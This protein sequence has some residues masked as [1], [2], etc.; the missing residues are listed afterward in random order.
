MND[1]IDSEP[2][3]LSVDRISPVPPAHHDLLVVGIGASA[4]GIPALKA[5]F[6]AMPADS[7][8]A[9]VVI[10]HLSRKHESH[11]AEIL[12]S[13]TGMTVTQVRETLSVEPNTVYVIPPGKHLTMV[14]GAITL[15]EPEQ[16]LGRRVPVDLLFRT[17][18]D[19]YG[20]NAVC[21]VL[22][23]T[24]TD[25][26]L[27]LKRVKESGGIAIVQ[28]PAEAEFAEM[29]RSAIE[30]HLAD[31]ILP[32]SEMPAKLLTLKL[33]ATKFDLPDDIEMPPNVDL[34]ADALREVLTLLRIRTGHDF[35]HYKRPTLMRRMAR[36]MM[37]HDLSDLPGYL[38][39]LREHPEELQSLLQDL[40]ISVTNFFRDS[41]VFEELE[42]EVIPKIFQGKNS[43]DQVRVWVAACATGEEAYTIAM[44]LCEYAENMPGDPPGIQVFA[45]DIDERAIAAARNGYYNDTIVADVSE[46]RLHRFFVKE[47]HH[48]RVKKSLREIVLFA[49][50]NLLRDPPFSKLDLISCRNLLIYLNRNTQESVFDVFHFSLR[51]GGF[52]LLA[53]S[54]SAEGAST[55]FSAINTKCRIYQSRAGASRYRTVPMMP[56]TGKWQ[57]NIPEV[58]AAGNDDIVS[59]GEIHRKLVERHALPSVLVNEDY[60]IVHSSERA[61]RYLRFLGGEP[62]RNLLK[63]VHP[64]LSLDLRA[65]LIE[66]TQEKRAAESHNVRIDLD[67]NR[68]AVDFIV[69]PC[70]TP[71]GFLLITFDESPAA[72]QDS[73]VASAGDIRERVVES[74]GRRLGEE[75][76][77]TKDRLRTTIEQNEISVEELRASNEELQAINE[78]LRSVSEELETSKEELQSVNEELTTVNHELKEKIDE[79]NESA[80]D[81]LNLMSSTDIGTI[82]LDLSLRIKRYT[83][84]VQA[85]F[86]IIPS[87]IGRPLE[88][89]THKLNYDDLA[90]DAAEVLRSLN[91]F[92][93]EVRS[94]DGGMYLTRFLP[95]R[96]I[97]DHVDGVV[98]SFIDINE[99]KVGEESRRWLSAI[100]SSSNDA[101]ISFTLDREIASWNAGAER[102]FGYTEAEALGQSMGMIVDPERAQA[103]IFAHIGRGESI[104]NF[105][106]ESV[107][108][109]GERI[110]VSLTVSP[111]V[112]AERTVLGIT[113]TVQ[114]ITSV[115]LSS[116]P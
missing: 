100:V 10:L 67:G 19:V 94:K 114:D 76:Q 69:R 15:V 99:R 89:L 12:Q 4:G 31:V 92:E 26:T 85:L 17:L 98:L 47:G 5:F 49:Q 84:A 59:F 9:F 8:M 113:A 74:I 70:D 73:E 18:G 87:D 82:F 101:I 106:S 107:R 1:S 27:G 96:T 46:E 3:K 55:R 53:P 86:N 78:E 40:L 58:P 66:A 83:P 61:G 21:V 43:G 14:D 80:S 36:R 111:I 44:L 22:S 48:Y 72:D 77:I 93:R 109:N 35:S 116:G 108:K 56:I 32:V 81:M 24:G 45:S 62:T 60:D 6:A 29:P 115:N 90:K 38:E 54:E 103:E 41:T 95:Y 79:A 63:V 105:Q 34:G 91:M 64:G 88:H 39:Y 33:N 57:M 2:D 37:V 30:T 71:A 104:A 52:L 16:S 7:G 75:L 25:G 28:D 50:H 102:V 11:L 68:I 112:D 110:N 23:G 51:S 20:K 42:R 97:D 13:E 65:T